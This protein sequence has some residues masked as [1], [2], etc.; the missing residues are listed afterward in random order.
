MRLI[1]AVAAMTLVGGCNRGDQ[2]LRV[3][4]YPASSQASGL[5]VFLPG[6][7]DDPESYANRGFVDIVRNA[8]PAFDVVSVDAHAAYYRADTV[9]E[10]L[11]QDVIDPRLASYGAIWIV[12]ISMGGFGA[13]LYAEAHPQDIAGVVLLAPFMGDGEVYREVRD[14][15][16]LAAWQFPASPDPD[17]AREY[18]LWSF[19]KQYVTQP[20]RSP[21]VYLGYGASDALAPRNRLLA[22]VL[23]AAQ[24]QEIPGGHDWTVWTPLFTNLIALAI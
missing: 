7:G 23:P 2:P 18:D 11:R 22:D 20:T 16:G 10:R 24:R 4:E 19:Y 17:L 9:V 8:N 15:G 13:S 3:L 6:L 12:G 14:A 21:L 5:I 1:I